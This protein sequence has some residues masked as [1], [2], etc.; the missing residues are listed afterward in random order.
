MPGPIQIK[1]PDIAAD[2]RALAEL[3]G[4][5]LTD[6]VADAVRSQLAIERVKSDS[7]L[8]KRRRKAESLLAELRRL[9]VTGPVLGDADIYDAKGL[10]K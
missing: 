7:R 4:L 1:R 9:P 5:S 2:I 10:P 8:A 3:T 6:A